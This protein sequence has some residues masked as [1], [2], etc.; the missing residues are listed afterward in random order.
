MFFVFAF[1]IKCNISLLPLTGQKITL[2]AA[3]GQKQCLSSERISG[4]FRSMS[5]QKHKMLPVLKW[6]VYI[7]FSRF[8]RCWIFS[9]SKVFPSS[10]RNWGSWCTLGLRSSTRNP[11]LYYGTAVW[12]FTCGHLLMIVYTSIYLYCKPGFGSLRRIFPTME[13]VCVY[14][15]NS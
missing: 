4:L 1:Y 5:L 6:E 15:Y 14:I 11:V 10:C 9:E 8:S 7:Y 13:W 2:H 12:G 3:R